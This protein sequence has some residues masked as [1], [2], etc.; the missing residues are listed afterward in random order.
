MGDAV[1]VCL[2]L[3]VSLRIGASVCVHEQTKCVHAPTLHCEA[4]IDNHVSVCN[5]PEFGCRG[6]VPQHGIVADMSP[7]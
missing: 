5:T 2:S 4:M 3:R 6:F 1:C 7:S